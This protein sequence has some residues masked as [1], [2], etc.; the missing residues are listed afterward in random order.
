MLEAKTSGKKFVRAHREDEPAVLNLMDALRRAWPTPGPAGRP[1]PA[2][3]TGETEEERP[4]G[5]GK[6]SRHPP[7]NGLKD[8]RGRDTGHHDSIRQGEAWA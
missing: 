2:R 1:R 3:E 6:T 7:Q 5:E 4:G 8:R